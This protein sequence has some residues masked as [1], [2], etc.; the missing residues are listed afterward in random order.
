MGKNDTEAYFNQ[1]WSAGDDDVNI[2]KQ[3]SLNWGQG[4]QREMQW[5]ESDPLLD[6]VGDRRPGIHYI[7]A[8]GNL[9]LGVLGAGQLTLPYAFASAGLI[10][11]IVFLG[12]L[13]VVAVVVLEILAKLMKGYPS[14]NN[15]GDVL[16]MTLGPKWRNFANVILMLYVWGGGISFFLVLKQEWQA[17]SEQFDFGICGACL[18]GLECTFIVFPLSL[19]KD[20]SKLRFTSYLGAFSAIC[21]TFTVVYTAPWSDDGGLVICGGVEE[22]SDGDI[23]SNVELDIGPQGIIFTINALPLMAFALNSAW[24]YLAILAQQ[25][26]VISLGY[27]ESGKDEQKSY[28]M[29]SEMAIQVPILGAKSLILVNYFILSIIGYLSYCNETQSNILQ[30]LGTSPLVVFARSVLIIQLTLALPLRYNVMRTTI[31]DGLLGNYKHL[32]E[33][34]TKKDIAMKV[35]VTFVT[36]FSACGIAAAVD[37]LET[38]VGLTS[39]IC[40]SF[41]IYIFPAL[42]YRHMLYEFD[43]QSLFKRVASVTLAAWGF[44]LMIAGVTAIICSIALGLTVVAG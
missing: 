37:S 7:T 10:L 14:A 18:L 26:T 19:F 28:E 32:W 16:D 15:Y 1:E 6:E 20:L 17:L 11:G 43:D 39:S 29:P 42:C 4:E 12:V 24:C 9:C 27:D 5:G 33:D 38:T 21:I 44:I 41:I 22:D 36:V 3:G 30:N 35:F 2:E 40:A 34:D 8:L 31:I 13:G 23:D 25:K